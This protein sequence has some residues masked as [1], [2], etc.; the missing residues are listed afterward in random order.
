MMIFFLFVLVCLADVLVSGR[1]GGIGSGIIDGSLTPPLIQRILDHDLEAAYDLL[2]LGASP[3][4]KEMPSGWT[5]LIYAASADNVELARHL[6]LAG[7]DV[8]QGC[9]DGWTPLMFASVHGKV[10]I[11][12]FLLEN[13]SNIHQVSKNGATALG[14]AKLGGFQ[15]AISL[16]NDALHSNRLTEIFCDQRGVEAVVL[17]ASHTSNVPLLERLLRD[18]HDPNTVSMGGW[19]PLMLSAAAGCAPCLSLLLE[20]GAIVDYQDKDGWTALMFCAHSGDVEGVRVLAGVGDVLLT[21]HQGVNSL[22]LARMEGHEEAFHVL[23]ARSF[24]RELRGQRVERMMLMIEDGVDPNYVCADVGNYTPLIVAVKAQDVEAVRLLLD[25]DRVNVNAVESDRWSPLMFASLRGSEEMVRLLLKAGADRGLLTAQG[26]SVIRLAQMYNKN[27][28]EAVLGMLENGLDF[29]ESPSV[30]TEQERPVEVDAIT[31][32]GETSDERTWSSIFSDLKRAAAVKRD[33]IQPY[34][35]SS[36][37]AHNRD[38]KRDKN[39]M[40]RLFGW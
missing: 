32:S 39:I 24:C 17:S 34:L 28:N 1:S 38:H 14:C 30:Y 40:A 15:A 5:P 12:T 33:V 18:G 35:P 36:E 2:A 9:A 31:K 13:G 3:N 4:V 25:D 27:N 16:V 23:V 26:F 7:A 10:S 19:T 29:T 6:V 11:M 21:N 20:A 37:E 22:H 8:N